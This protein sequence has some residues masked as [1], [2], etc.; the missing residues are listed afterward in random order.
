MAK[1]AQPEQDMQTQA[2]Q[3]VKA[4]HDDKCAEINGREYHITNI[5]HIKRR[6]VFAFFTHIQHDLQ[7]QDMWFLESKEW[8]EVERVI[9]NCV[10]FNGDLLSKLNTHWDDYPEDYM[11]FIQTMLG[12]ISYPFL[13]GVNGG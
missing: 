8:Q 11:L 10:T 6:K 2:M 9:E 3:M 12:A 5:N 7:R 4:V 1:K 13:S